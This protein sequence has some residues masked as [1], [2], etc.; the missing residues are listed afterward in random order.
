MIPIN[1]GYGLKLELNQK[2]M[3]TPELRQAIAIL[4]L[5]ALE[6]SDMIEQEIIENPVL[7]IA[8]KEVDDPEADPVNENPKEQLD[9]YLN[10]DDYF[11]QGIDKKSEYMVVD[12][13]K[14][15]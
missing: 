13:R 4:Q 15:Y 11:N 3:M 14:N 10:W 2:L 5:S 8:E 6:L 1:L 12:D 9:D 7:E